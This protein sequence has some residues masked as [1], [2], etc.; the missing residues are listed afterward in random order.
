MA[1]GVRALGA[2]WVERILGHRVDPVS[3]GRAVDAVVERALDVEP[4]A[5]V[6]LTN[7]HSTIESRRFPELRAAVDGAFLSVPDGMPLAWILRRRGYSETEKVT[8]IEYVPLVASKGVDLGLRHFFY[9]GGP[10]IAVRAGVRVESLVPG[11]KLV[12]AASPPFN[13]NGQW[14][15]HELERDLRRTRPHILWVGLGA[16]KQEIW[17][18]HMA[19]RLS[20]PVMIGVGAAFDYLAGSKASA[21]TALRHIGLE[22]LFRLAVEPKRLWH[23]YL[24]GNSKFVMLLLREALTDRAHDRPRGT[25]GH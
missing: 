22:W 14:P 2:P 5:Y 6:C 4:G 9:G 15:I 23:R 16:P 1:V 21:P 8:G 17:M 11:M 13:A 19:G 25:I 10:G 18:S 24:I 7:V 3:K 12:G 20:V